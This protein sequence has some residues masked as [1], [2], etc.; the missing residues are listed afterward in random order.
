[1]YIQ[2]KGIYIY[3]V[4]SRLLVPVL[5]LLLLHGALL[6]SLSQLEKS[7]SILHNY[8]NGTTTKTTFMKQT[9]N[10]SPFSNSGK[11]RKHLFK[12]KQQYLTV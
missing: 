7:A 8:K 11:I 5:A 9:R 10:Q 6:L 4:S 12:E 3:I 1:M 2:C